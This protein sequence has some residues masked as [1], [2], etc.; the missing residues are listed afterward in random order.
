MGR[1]VV[2]YDGSARATEAV[3]WAAE[4][5]ERRQ[6]DLHLVESWIEP[7]YSDRTYNDVLEVVD[8]LQTAAKSD[9]EE[10]AAEVGR[11][12]P[13]LRCTTEVAGDLPVLSLVAAA[14]GAELLVVG[15]RGR[16]GFASALLGSVSQG[17]VTRSRAPVVVVRGPVRAEGPVVV[18]V[19]GSRP[20]RVALAW[21]ADEAR[22]HGV[23]LVAL[24]TWSYLL[25]IGE[26][27]L[28]AM[29]AGYTEH[30]AREALAAIV[31]DVLG[32]EPDVP[33]ERRVVCGA[34]S[35]ALVEAGEG[36]SLL[37]VGPRAGA[38]RSPLH[39]GSVTIR[40]LHHA[41]CPLAVV[42]ERP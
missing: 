11:Q 19:D 17:V 12:H 3:H 25:P 34:P 37:V 7:V 2:G 40:L 27:G 8:Q 28:E 41:S 4:E 14:E 10:A 30:D 33:V 38:M 15:A 35:S 36:A 24:L 39:L 1:I 22:R 6:A 21:A 26:H 31:R 29:R 23:G 32:T 16:G 9:L 18:G 5:A 20:S 42:R 13:A